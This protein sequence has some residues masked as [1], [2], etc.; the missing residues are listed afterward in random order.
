M[1]SGTRNPP[2]ISTSSPRDTIDLA[3]ARQRAEREQH[4]GGVVVDDDPGLGA[5]R[6]ASKRPACSWREPRVP[7]HAGT[8]GSSSPGTTSAAAASAS[9]IRAGARPRLVCTITPVALTTR[10]QQAASAAASTRRCASAI[11]S[12]RPLGPAARRATRSRA[13]ST[14]SR[15]HVDEQRL[16]E[17]STSGQHRVDTGQRPPRVHDPGSL[18]AR[19]S[20]VGGHVRPSRLRA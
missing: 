9:S 16:R 13:S 2:P 1:I 14:A 6:R 3:A 20:P 12:S 19:R 11:T 15:A 10:T 18:G 5:A 8:R 17:A 7:L 4:R